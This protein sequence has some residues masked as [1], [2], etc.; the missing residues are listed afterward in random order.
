VSSELAAARVVREGLFQVDPPALLVGRCAACGAI[1]FPLRAFCPECQSDA[2]TPAPLSGGG[3]IYS[4]TIVRAAP[5]GYLGEAPYAIGVVELDEGLR[6]ASTLVCD[7]LEDLSIEDRVEFELLT[8][9]DEEPVRSY[10]Y[11][12]S[13][14]SR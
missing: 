3:T 7:D 13:K 2:V 5:P 9:G 8:L 6:I 12:V 1:H 10:V 14:A 4:Y 11:R